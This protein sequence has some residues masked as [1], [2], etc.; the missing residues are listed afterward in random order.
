MDLEQFDENR[1]VQ[2]TATNR[3][4][5]EARKSVE[6]RYED[7]CCLPGLVDDVELQKRIRER[8]PKNTRSSTAWCENVW[9]DWAMKRN[10]SEENV[11]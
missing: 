1:L 11:C 2:T 6:G 5:C 9:I 7:N 10:R 8:I 4:E 3:D